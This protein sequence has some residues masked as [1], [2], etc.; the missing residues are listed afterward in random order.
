MTG[1][2][3]TKPAL[4]HPLLTATVTSLIV[5]AEGATLNDMDALHWS[6]NKSAPAGDRAGAIYDEMSGRD[7]LQNQRML[8][9]VEEQYGVDV[10]SSSWGRQFSHSGFDHGY[11]R[12]GSTASFLTSIEQVKQMA[13]DE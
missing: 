5:G 6:S 7:V 13:R 2:S 10:S 11:S 8:K 3:V 1:L 4:P 9:A 12:V